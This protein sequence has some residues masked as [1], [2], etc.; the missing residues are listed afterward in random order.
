MITKAIVEKVIDRYNI[1]I[2]VP[3]LDRTYQSNVHKNNE[4][5]DVAIVCTLPGCDPNIK[6]GDIVFVSLEKTEEDRA[7]ILGYLYR[8]KQT[9]TYCDMIL[10]KLNVRDEAILPQN[11]MIGDIT[12]YEVKQL[13]GA[14]GNIQAQ[15]NQLKNEVDR[16]RSIV[17]SM[18]GGSS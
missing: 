8:T 13:S 7:V 17:S 15:I 3:S 18:I 9:E 4:D 2:R 11:T 14:T 10:S 5:L 16:L 1:R 12:S 6:V